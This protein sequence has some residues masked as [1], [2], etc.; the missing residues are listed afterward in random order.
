MSR[1]DDNLIVCR[2]LVED[3]SAFASRLREADRQELL[4]AT[5]DNRLLRLLSASVMSSQMGFSVWT[6]DMTPVALFGVSYRNALTTEAT[7]WL[8]ATDAL[9]QHWREFCRRTREY[10]NELVKS[11]II[12]TNRIDARND[13]ALR[14]IRWLGAE[15]EAAEP[16]GPF[17]LPFHRFE[18]RL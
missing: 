7:L 17:G 11:P 5:G 4:A 10:L 16:F 1:P 13:K 15:I 3:A 18:L 12:M 9:A 8:V 6:C 14:Y 2:A